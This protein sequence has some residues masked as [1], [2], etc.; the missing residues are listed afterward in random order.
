MIL[1]SET[2]PNR[3]STETGHA[4]YIC[5]DVLWPIFYAW[6]QVIYVIFLP[7]HYRIETDQSAHSNLSASL[8]KL[9]TSGR[10]FIADADSFRGRA[11]RLPELG[12]S[13][14][15][16]HLRRIESATRSYP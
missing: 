2:E 7:F 13:D 11:V 9:V 10:V 4:R 3:R 5:A 1:M 16:R 12:G 15:S 14:W 6:K 8:E